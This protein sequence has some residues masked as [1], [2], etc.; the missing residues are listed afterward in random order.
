KM[1][2]YLKKISM[3][4]SHDFE[5]NDSLEIKNTVLKN[6]NKNIYRILFYPPSNV[7]STISNPHKD[8]NL[9]T[10]LPFA[11]LEGLEI[12]LKEGWCEVNF[13]CNECLVIFGEM[14]ESISN[15]KYMSTLHRV[16]ACKKRNRLSSAFFVNPDSE[17]NISGDNAGDLLSRRLKRITVSSIL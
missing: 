15:G 9:F 5:T 10:L 7:G 14:L 12:K 11:S 6:L 8:I 1:Y 16:V 2:S 3:Q 17:F 13:Q 4:I